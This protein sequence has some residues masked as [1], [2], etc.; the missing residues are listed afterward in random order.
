MDQHRES[1]LIDL[2]PHLPILRIFQMDLLKRRMELDS[3]HLHILQLFQFLDH[4][5]TVRVKAA[6]WDNILPCRFL[7]EPVHLRLILGF[8]DHRQV[9]GDV[10]PRL[11]HPRQQILPDRKLLKIIILMPGDLHGPSR[12]GDRID[13]RMN[14]NDPAIHLFFSSSSSMH[15]FRQHVPEFFCGFGFYLQ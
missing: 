10:H 13:M 3:R 7:R 1:Q 2:S 8:R 9:H 12:Q 4:I 11:L 5:L 14:V 6:E 15:R